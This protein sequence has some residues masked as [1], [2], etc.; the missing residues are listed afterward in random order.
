MFV[1]FKICVV[2]HRYVS[3][4]IQTCISKCSLFIKNV[5]NVR[6]ANVRHVP[7]KCLTYIRKKISTCI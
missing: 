6:F 7:E 4:K 1:P 2:S 3:E 5:I